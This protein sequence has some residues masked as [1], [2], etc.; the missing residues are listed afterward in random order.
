MRFAALAYAY[1]LWLLPALIML[2]A[3]AFA[4]KRQALAAFIDFALLPRLVPHYSRLRPGL[5][6]A[7]LLAAVASFIL[8]L[9]QP[10]W[11][12]E[13]QEVQRQGRD[14]MIILDV[15]RSMLAEDVVP[16]RL[17]RAKNDIKDL[18]QT[19]H[20]EGGH[21]LGLVV[22]AGQA[23][24]QCP[25]TL[26]YGFFLQRLNQAGPETVA[27][28]GTLMG[29]AIRK[30][31]SAFAT[32][33]NNHKDIILITDGEDQESAPLEAAQ[34]AAAQQ[35]SI[36]TI[37]VGDAI[38]GTRIPIQDTTGHRTY[39]QHQGQEV[40]SRMQQDTLLEMARITGGAYVPA[41]TRSIELDRIYTE[42]I[43]PKARYQTSMTRRE[44]FIH[45]YQ[46]FVLA[47]LVLLSLDM[48]I[49]EGREATHAAQPTAL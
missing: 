44:R 32:L 12:Q 2:Y 15:S 4:R 45:R 10:Q 47:G 31:L 27:R 38:T 30:A 23:S 42:K 7:C 39:L 17:E 43:A 11:G 13:W 49:R 29:D 18:V 35:V 34:A 5:K 48:I 1:L 8:A 22:F 33:A 24:L 36:Y 46:W 14:L 6:A 25:L 21:R 28:G 26:D 19:L 41:G 16:N 40:R 9:M 3:Y 20:K 37:G